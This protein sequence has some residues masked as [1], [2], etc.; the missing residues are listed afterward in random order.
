MGRH[1]RQ[2]YS[3][4]ITKY[5]AGASVQS[6]ADEYGIS[7]PGMINVL[8]TFG[9]KDRRDHDKRI[10]IRDKEDEVVSLYEQ[11]MRMKDIA[12]KFS[13]TE[14][15][16]SLTLKKRGT[17]ARKKKNLVEEIFPNAADMGIPENL[18]QETK[19]AFKEFQKDHANEV[20]TKKISDP[21]YID[22]DDLDKIE[23]DDI[24]NLFRFY[25]DNN[26]DSDDEMDY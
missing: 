12:K 5:Y 14:A 7:R 10:K 13:C 4:A 26:E 23:N 21:D 15:I 11:G 1:P 22:F 19:T 3:G 17:K 2:D 20:L 8:S 25:D 6:L 16:V 24:D 9:I 18:H